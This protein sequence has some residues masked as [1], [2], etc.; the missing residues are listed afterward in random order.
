MTPEYYE[1]IIRAVECTVCLSELGYVCTNLVTNTPNKSPHPERITAFRYEMLR[2]QTYIAAREKRLEREREKE[3]R[4]QA[5]AQR[6][7]LLNGYRQY[8]V[9]EARQLS[10]W[11]R[12]NWRIFRIDEKF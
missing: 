9:E 5:R 7:A 8:G 12:E 2:R 4:D 1:D 3:L 10:A 6:Q 11:L